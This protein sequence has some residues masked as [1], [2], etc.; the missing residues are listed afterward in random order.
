MMKPSIKGAW[1]AAAGS[2][3]RGVIVAIDVARV[4]A[5]TPGC[6]NVLHLNN[7][8]ASLS[9]RAVVER[10]K[11]HLDLEA[12][13]GGYEA[14]DSAA[15]E[16]ERVYRSIAGML[17]C[18]A[19]EIAL[20][21]SATRAWDAAFYALAERF[22]PGDKILTA[23]NE[24]VSNYLAFLQVARK[25][26]VDIVVVPS[27]EGGE[28]SL[29]ALEA[30]IDQH[31]QRVKLIALTHVPSNGGLV[32]PAAAVGHIARA[33]RVPFLLDA[34]Q[35][36]GQT[37]L[38]VEELGCDMLSATG[39]K[40]LRG[41]RGTGFL[42]VRR[43][44]VEQLEPTPLDMRSATWTARDQYE[45]RKDAR[46]FETWESSLA[47]RLGL[48]VA[49]EYARAVGLEDIAERVTM[50]AEQ[51]RDDLAGIAGVTM[52]DLPGDGSRKRCGIVTFTH[53][54]H[55]AHAIFERMRERRINVRV[56]P[57]GS[58]RIDMEERGL[59]EMVRA[60]VHYYNTEG[61]LGRF[62]RAIRDL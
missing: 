49:V 5:D 58:T 55:A 10:V 4:R 15:E 57:V 46:R 38:D 51:L 17:G 52:R 60:S 3:G 21:E 43:S 8:G 31:G 54:R 39:R 26:G 37:P 14:A 25:R 16:S 9:P 44:L 48:G 42:Y 34:C 61:E 29:T 40:Y 1:P 30:A 11:A 62:A 18:A 45:V 7:A 28:I 22:E 2:R 53:E 19:E 6:E 47:C 23:A 59:T 32:Q 35:S 13:M 50:L 12:A 27:E 33:N 56:T 41:P 36:A 20:V 24:Y